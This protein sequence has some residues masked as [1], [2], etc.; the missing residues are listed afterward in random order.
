MYADFINDIAIFR[1]SPSNVRKSIAARIIYYYLLEG[2]QGTEG[3]RSSVL[4]EEFTARVLP[5]NTPVHD[6]TLDDELCMNWLKVSGGSIQEIFNISKVPKTPLEW[7]AQGLEDAT[8]LNDVEITATFFD[9]LDLSV[10]TYLRNRHY[11]G[12]RQSELCATFFRLLERAS[13]GNH[14]P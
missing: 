11:A 9:S 8:V 6:D 4:L 12:F 10:F 5:H 14:F 13:K 7:E 1:G 2:S 3:R